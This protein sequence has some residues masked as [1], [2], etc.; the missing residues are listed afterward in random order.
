M[1]MT[2]Q[3]MG[4][5]ILGASVPM[6]A[7]AN[8]DLPQL[9]GRIDV[10]INNTELGGADASV[11]TNSNASRLGVHNTHS[12]NDA[13]SVFYR[14]EYEVNPDE[15]LRSTDRGMLRQRNSVVGIKTEYGKIFVGVHDT[16]MKKA[17]LKVDLFSDY[18][19]AD[20]DEVLAGQDRVSD[21]IN[22]VS[23]KFKQLGGSLQGWLMFIPGDD[24]SDEPGTDSGGGADAV[25]GDGLADAQSASLVFKAEALQLGLA[26]NNNIDGRDL[27][28]VSG[29]YAIGPFKL[30]AIVQQAQ[31]SDGNGEDGIGFV[32]SAAVKVLPE[33]V[34]K[35]QYASADDNSVEE[36]PGADLLT[37]GWDFKLAKTTK[38]YAY[39]SDRSH[40]TASE[41]FSTLGVGIRHAFGNKK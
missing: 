13:V 26:Y 23:P 6:T 1:K 10:S 22:Y 41:E 11:N 8:A 29:Q 40:D 21:T 18:H 14:L 24:A 38:L 12:L 15:R 30:G 7:L 28:R 27:L 5:L 31:A 36:T 34:L 3:I 35:L 17:E 39:Y 9:Y 2:K 33:H 4:G 25:T 19:L 32:T 37:L 16:P 20:I